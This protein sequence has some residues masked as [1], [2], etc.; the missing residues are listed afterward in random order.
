MRFMSTRKAGISIAAALLASALVLPGLVSAQAVTSTWTAT[1]RGANE[2]PPT[3]STATATFTATLNETSNSLQWTLSVPA[4]TSITAA[5]LHAG[6][7]GVNGGVILGLYTP[8]TGTTPVGTLNLSGTASVLDL[9]GTYA[10]NF[11]GFVAALKAGTIYANV[12]TTANPGGEIR[13]QV[14]STQATPTPT[15]APTAAATAAPT[16]A[17]TAAPTAAATTAPAATAVAPA[18]PKTGSAGL[19]D[20]GTGIAMAALLGA[21][22]VG[23]VAGGRALA[24]RRAG[25]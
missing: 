20:G 21:L 5:H 19:M 14:V 9:S 3:T 7:A 17:A 12:H 10:N 11:A 18:P 1:L 16:A 25:R 15:A 23:A 6:A 8:A 2:V 4:A 24:G 22:A 13:A